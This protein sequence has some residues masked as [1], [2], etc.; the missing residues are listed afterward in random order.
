M[1]KIVQ[2]LGGDVYQGGKRA[3]IP[4]P[5]HS[6][7]DRS[8]SLMLGTEG[9]VRIY[10]FSDH[11]WREVMEWLKRENLVG[12]DH[13]LLD[14]GLRRTS[15]APVQPHRERIAA[16]HRI[17]E[18][19]RAVQ[20][21]LSSQWLKVRRKIGRAIDSSAFRH[22]P[23]VPIKAYDQNCR[24]LQPAFLAKVVM[25]NGEHVGT[26]ITYLEAGG[27]K[28]SSLRVPRKLIGCKPPGAAVVIDPVDDE[29]VVAEGV[30]SALSA[31][32]HF[33]LPCYALLGVRSF[34]QWRPPKG[35]RRVVIA[36]E[37][38][39]S[40]RAFSK[41][42]YDTLCHEGF[43]CRLEFAPGGAKDFNAF[44]GGTG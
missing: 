38:D 8:I 18:E 26:E 28:A 37:P 33:D 12:P 5:G 35:V 36:A 40:G 16:A 10:P 17:W 11:D 24:F 13:T 34:P 22:G 30:P 29:M 1:Y 43:D 9:K 42:L 31:S 20:Q 25:P 14:R 7:N 3:L 23:A 39:P 4:G 6:R 21:S 15:Y 2:K 44:F 19:G 27:R 41:R 32:E